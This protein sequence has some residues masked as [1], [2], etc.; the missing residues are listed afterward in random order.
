MLFDLLLKICLML[1]F[2]TQNEY[3]AVKA[4]YT[5]AST[6]CLV[7]NDRLYGRSA[8]PILPR[9]EL[10]SSIINDTD[11]SGDDVA[12]KCSRFFRV[13]M[14]SKLVDLC[15]THKYCDSNPMSRVNC[16]FLT[17]ASCFYAPGCLETICRIRYKQ[18]Q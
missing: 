6:V 14:H 15:K 2:V 8:P 3:T 18:S 11:V 12:A 13:Q 7:R 4:E 1:S 10:I 5:D 17:I 9:T 16:F